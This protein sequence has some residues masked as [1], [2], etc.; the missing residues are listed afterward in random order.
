MRNTVGFELADGFRVTDFDRVI[1]ELC[2]S[3]L[4]RSCRTRRARAPL[5]CSLTSQRA[6][7]S[8]TCFVRSPTMS[9]SQVDVLLPLTT[10]GN[11]QGPIE[12]GVGPCPG[13]RRGRCH[14]RRRYLA[15]SR[16]NGRSTRA[17]R[18]QRALVELR[19]RHVKT[20][21]LRTRM[22]DDV[23]AR[24]RES[25]NCPESTRVSRNTWPV[26]LAGLSTVRR[27]S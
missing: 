1:D 13:V 8:R 24:N 15:A 7:L 17:R 16:V 18:C 20:V 19:Q 12:V 9:S 5:R 22:R 26:R 10:A 2:R 6:S 23:A 14:P 27:T 4:Q 11:T 3:H 25:C 21:A